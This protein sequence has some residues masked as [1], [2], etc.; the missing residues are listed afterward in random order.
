MRNAW[1]SSCCFHLVVLA[2][3]MRRSAALL[4]AVAAIFPYRGDH[5]V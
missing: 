3:G 4:S 2:L 5:G 1:N